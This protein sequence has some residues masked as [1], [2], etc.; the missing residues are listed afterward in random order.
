MRAVCEP[1]GPRSGG[2]TQSHHVTNTCIAGGRAL[3][4]ALDVRARA[5]ASR[6]LL[7]LLIAPNPLKRRS[8]P[9]RR[10]QA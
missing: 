6:P 7:P 9:S 3:T 10:C 4:Y 1:L 2:D 5:R 8:W